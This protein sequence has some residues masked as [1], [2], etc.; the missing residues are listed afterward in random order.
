MLT[1]SRLF[2]NG[3]VDTEMKIAE[4]TRLSD[5]QCA[6]IPKESKV[7]LPL[8]KH[9]L[10]RE[11]TRRL[12]Y[13]DIRKLLNHPAMMPKDKFEKYRDGK[14]A[15]PHDLQVHLSGKVKRRARSDSAPSQVHEKSP[16]IRNRSRSNSDPRINRRVKSRSRSKSLGHSAKKLGPDRARSAR[17]Q[18]PD[19]FAGF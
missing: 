19:P 8:I 7:L 17:K 11:P 1:G 12:G 5:R 10:Q 15:L 9:L 6:K 14:L 16:C 3:Y 2:S 18:T 13:G 4:Y